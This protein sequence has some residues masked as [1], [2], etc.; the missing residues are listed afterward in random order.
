MRDALGSVQSVALFGATSE[1]GAAIVRALVADRARRIVLL[2]RHENPSL[3]ADP[4][5]VGA[6]VASI[7]FDALDVASHARL[8]EEAVAAV[9]D[10]LGLAVVAFGMLGRQGDSQLDDAGAL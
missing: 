7:H 2:G 3:A 6:A 5:A 8:V 4:R 10:D 9:G 1:I